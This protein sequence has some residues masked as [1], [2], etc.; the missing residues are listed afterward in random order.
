MYKFLNL[1][2]EK[3]FTTKNYISNKSIIIDINLDKT[4]SMVITFSMNI[5]SSQQTNSKP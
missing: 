1:L 5:V 4:I 3:I 2:N